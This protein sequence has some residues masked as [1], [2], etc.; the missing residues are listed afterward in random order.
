M[1]FRDPQAEFADICEEHGV[2]RQLS[3]VERLYT[4]SQCQRVA[5]GLDSKAAS[6]QVRG[7]W[8]RTC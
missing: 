3:E 5:S 1:A 7:G 8:E 4:A 6:I 2:E